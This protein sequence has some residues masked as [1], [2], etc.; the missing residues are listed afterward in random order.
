MSAKDVCSS[1]WR[2][3]HSSTVTLKN[4]T[5]GPVTVS[6]DSSCTWPFPKEKKSGFT[7]NAGGTHDVVLADDP[8][9]SYCYR[10]T[11]CPGDPLK[12]NPKTVIIT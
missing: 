1:G 10:T 2:G 8:T 7:I 6:A 5:S 9:Q 3:V 4:P 11:G 12:V